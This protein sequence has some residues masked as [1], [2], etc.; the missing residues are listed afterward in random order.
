MRLYD[1]MFLWRIR[2]K[3]SCLT[4]GRFRGPFKILVCERRDGGSP[5]ATD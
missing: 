5:S 3:S 1:R 4:K 2:E